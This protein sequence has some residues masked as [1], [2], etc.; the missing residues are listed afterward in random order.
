MKKTLTAIAILFL[1]SL[2]TIYSE[3][4][5]LNKEGLLKWHNYY[6]SMHGVSKLTW[7]TDL[8]RLAK[9]WARHLAQRNRMYHRPNNT[10]GENI[11]WSKGYTPSSKRPV[12]NWYDEIAQYSYSNPGFS[13][14]TGHFTQVIWKST[15]ELGCG[16]ATARDGGIYV[17]CN[18]DPPGNYLGRFRE[19]V[20]PKK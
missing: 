8:E 5:T 11:H 17:V 2:S 13:Y 14:R 12:K 16:W 6:R 4:G 1:I 19:N 18:Y 15:K 9:N 7:N 20:L 3:T 10:K